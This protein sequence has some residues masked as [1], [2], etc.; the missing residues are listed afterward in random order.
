MSVTA[1]KL[2]LVTDASDQNVRLEV[3]PIV[4]EVRVYG[5]PGISD[6]TSFTGITSASVKTGGGN[7][8][9]ALDAQTFADFAVAVDTGVGEL[10][11]TVQWKV[12]QSANPIA[13][14][15]ELVTLSGPN[16]FANVEFVNDAAK[17]K[18]NARV[19]VATASTTKILSV[20]PTETL[21]V[22]FFGS[23]KSCSGT[24]TIMPCA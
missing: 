1:G 9:F 10:S 16:Q 8:Q 3:G 7:D 15:F 2:S 6:G 4:G 21:D 14:N 13:A 18:I 12:G 19:G 11:T 5:F 20:D 17:A 24:S 22:G 23:A